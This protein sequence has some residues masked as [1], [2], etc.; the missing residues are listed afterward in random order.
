MKLQYISYQ[1]MAKGPWNLGVKLCGVG[2]AVMA[3]NP[4]HH[5]FTLPQTSSVV[6]SFLKLYLFRKG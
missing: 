2:N 4:N 1:E 3:A 5:T 6:F